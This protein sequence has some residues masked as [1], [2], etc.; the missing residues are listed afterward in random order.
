MV[1]NNMIKIL[2][3]GNSFSQDATV[4]LHDT[5]NCGNIDTK[6]VNLFIGGC[7]LLTHWKN[8]EN[9]ASDYDYE[10]NGAST[11]RKISIKEALREDSWDFVTLQQASHDSGII[12]TYYPYITNLSDYV[13]KYSPDAKQLIHQTWAYET[14]SSH[15]AFARYEKNQELMYKSLRA[16]YQ[17]ASEALGLP[18][19]PSGDV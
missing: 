18:I 5:A 17:K 13:K 11:G 12:E 19:I 1:F 8:A 16:A 15:G 2:A 3:I 6:I 9:D 14:D 4:Y 7:S 10:L